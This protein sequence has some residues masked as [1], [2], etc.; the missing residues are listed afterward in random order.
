MAAPFLTW[1]QCP[2]LSVSPNSTLL[3]ALAAGA[4]TAAPA[5]IST[6]APHL[7]HFLGVCERLRTIASFLSSVP[8]LDYTISIS[9]DCC[10]LN[11]EVGTFRSKVL[12]CGR[13]FPVA[14]VAG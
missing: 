14:V 11:A 5:A 1:N 13:N 2:G 8:D 10:S 3:S 7:R 4:R 12:T 6:A 9:L